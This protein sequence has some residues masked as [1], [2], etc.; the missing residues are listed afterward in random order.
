MDSSD[1]RQRALFFEVHRDLPR[2]GPGDQASTLRALDIALRG[3]SVEAPLHVADVACGPGMQ[4]LHL[5]S[6]L[7]QAR[8]LAMDLHEPFL[9][10]LSASAT[11]ASVHQRV[12]PVRA[13]MTRLPVRAA[14]L[15]LVWC[16]GAAYIMG[17]ADALNAWRPMLRQGGVCA[18]TEAVWLKADPPQQVRACWAEYPAMGDIDAVRET[19]RCGGYE[20]MGDFV[21]PAAAWWDDYYTPMAARLDV[22]EARY[23]EDAA[24]Q[25][26]LTA[27]REEIDVCRRFGDWYGYAFFVAGK[28]VG[29]PPNQEEAVTCRAEA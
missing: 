17:I 26:V 21:L 6:A 13:D 12:Q 10:Q 8:I 14:S 29:T 20:L 3:R 18:F 7:P 24:A 25:S 27:C 1:S 28:P 11:A 19:V 9:H 16:E 4:T 2:E 22:L 23:G 15:D 5:A